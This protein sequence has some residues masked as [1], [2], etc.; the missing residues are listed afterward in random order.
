MHPTGTATTCHTRRVQ[1]LSLLSG[2]VDS[3][4]VFY[5]TSPDFVTARLAVLT[6]ILGRATSGRLRAGRGAL[7]L[8]QEIYHVQGSLAQSCSPPEEDSLH[9]PLFLLL[10]TCPRSGEKAF[11]LRPL[12][13]PGE[14]SS[15]SCC[16]R[17]PPPSCTV[18]TIKLRA[19]LVD[20]KS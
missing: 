17:E 19:V 3:H 11:S 16:Q 8:G 18:C 14:T 1:I 4:L 6:S 13:N 15:G 2:N 20:S 9:P 12:R 7:H 10:L 5:L